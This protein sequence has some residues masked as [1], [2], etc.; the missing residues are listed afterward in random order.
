MLVSVVVKVAPAPPLAAP[1][2]IEVAPLMPHQTRK[3]EQKCG[4]LSIYGVIR[5]L[6]TGGAAQCYNRHEA[7]RL[8]RS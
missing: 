8:H 7:R 6:Q 1:L 5:L 3:A 2:V 4:T